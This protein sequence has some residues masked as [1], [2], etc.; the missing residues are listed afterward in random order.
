[1]AERVAPGEDQYPLCQHLTKHR[2]IIRDEYDEA[3]TTVL[4]PERLVQRDRLLPRLP[5]ALAR[6]RVADA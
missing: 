3:Q 4:A 1:M 6:L 2:Y 5:S